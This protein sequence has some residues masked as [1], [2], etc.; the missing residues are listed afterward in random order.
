MLAASTRFGG[1]GGRIEPGAAASSVTDFSQS[2]CS[3]AISLGAVG[4]TGL[5]NIQLMP[6]RI[7]EAPITTMMVP[8]TTGGK[9][10]SIRLTSGAIRMPTT[11]A[12]MIAPKIIRAP[13]GPGLALAIATMGPTE[14]NVTPIM[15]GSLMPNHCVAP[16]DWMSVTKP[17]TNK[18]AEI[19]KATCSGSSLSA[20]PMM[21]GTA[22]APAYMT[23]TCWTPSASRRGAGS[24]SSTG[25]GFDDMALS[26]FVAGPK[27]AEEARFSSS[28]AWCSI[29]SLG[30]AG[31]AE[32]FEILPRFS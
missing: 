6:M 3:G 14:A 12:P 19:R 16:S 13:S 11:P 8:V 21:S 1:S 15:T 20:R 4:P 7:S 25:C 10:R 18:S 17:H 29:T 9:N 28:E 23:S 5:P 22:I 30:R 31:H 32:Y 26:P 24:T 2:A 27:N